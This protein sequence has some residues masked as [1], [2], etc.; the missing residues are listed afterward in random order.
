MRKTSIS[1]ICLAMALS[2][3]AQGPTPGGTINNKI[4]IAAPTAANLGTFG[5]VPVNLST[6]QLGLSVPIEPIV[7]HDITIPVKLDYSYQGFKPNEHPGWTGIGWSL[8]AGGVITRKKNGRV[9]EGAIPVEANVV[10][11]GVSHCPNPPGYLYTTHRQ[12]LYEK[13]PSVMDE[14]NYTTLL[15]SQRVLGAQGCGDFPYAYF[16]T[17][18]DE[19]YFNFNGFSGK[20]M[21][22]NSPWLGFVIST[23]SNDVFDI[24]YEM[25]T[26]LPI[27]SDIPVLLPYYISKF[28]VKT[29]DGYTY[30]FGGDYPNQKGLEIFYGMNYNANENH[31]PKWRGKDAYISSWYLTKIISPKGAVANFKYSES[32]FSAGLYPAFDLE[33]INHL[34][35]SNIRRTNYNWYSTPVNSNTYLDSITCGS[36]KVV[37]S[38]S[39]SSKKLPVSAAVLWQD[40]YQHEEVLVD[41]IKRFGITFN[42][43]MNNGIVAYETAYGYHNFFIRDANL[44]RSFDQKWQKL[45]GIDYYLDNNLRT[46]YRFD[47]WK[48]RQYNDDTTS[49]GTPG[50][51]ST[52]RLELKSIVKRGRTGDY[53]PHYSFSYEGQYPDTNVYKYI[54]YGTRQIDHWGFYNGNDWLFNTYPDTAVIVVDSALGANY[55]RSRA[56]VHSVLNRGGIQSITYPTG[57]RT[58][59]TYEPNTIRKYAHY[60]SVLNEIILVDLGKDSAV[61]GY[62]VRSIRSQDINVTTQPVSKDYFYTSTTNYIANRESSGVLNSGFPNYHR[63]D[64]NN[65]FSVGLIPSTMRG[66]Q[67][68]QTLSSNSSVPLFF[69]NSFLTYTDVVERLGNQSY[70]ASHFSNSD[71]SPEYRD[72][73]DIL[74]NSST[75]IYNG[76]KFHWYTS[77]E[78][79]RGKLLSESYYTRFD[80]IVKLVQYD[81]NNEPGRF[82]AKGVNYMKMDSKRLNAGTTG[83]YNL[84]TYLGTHPGYHGYLKSTLTTNYLSGSP[85]LI[86]TSYEYDENRNKTKETTYTNI[87]DGTEEITRY[88]NNT[89][90]A[91]ASNSS[92]SFIASVK[93]LQDKHLFKLPVETISN[94]IRNYN[95]L[96]VASSL[97]EYDTSTNQ[98]KS[99]SELETNAPIVNFAMASINGNIFSKHPDMHMDKTHIVGYN[100]PYAYPQTIINDRNTV[101]EIRSYNMDL[102][103]ATAVNASADDIYYNSFELN[104]REGWFVQIPS[105]F[106]TSDAVTGKTSVSLNGNIVRTRPN[107]LKIGKKYTLTYWAKGGTPILNITPDNGF[108][109]IDSLKGWQLY[110]ATFTAQHVW[111]EFTGTGL[112]DEVRVYPIGANMKSVTYDENFRILDMCNP[113]SHIVRY[114]YDEFDRLVLT[115]DGKG[116]IIQKT[117][118]GLQVTE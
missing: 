17:E 4:E 9:D 11:T 50:G 55:A 3:Q 80:T 46:S 106:T 91:P 96:T 42:N 108:Q 61:G 115:R 76:L 44:W 62:R 64:Y 29:H 57:G 77:K 60:D 95:P 28:T 63:K 24:T 49:I 32:G 101:S 7:F 5:T 51:S 14:T 111:V 41:Y 65:N 36:Q 99:H 37:F 6:G 16:D 43:W 72:K 40:R 97:F 19:F 117:E 10:D 13:S 38:R 75:Y 48:K 109:A 1:L 71:V 56:S 8:T 103:I 30:E 81:Y 110:K 79:E 112:L 113:A 116:N 45:T 86:S 18:P 114:E 78:F 2:G 70:I 84:R 53:R 69:E 105:L 39:G 83:T 68:Y 73:V 35:G 104:Q 102:Q 54:D 26:N 58:T 82:Y 66:G 47:Y 22:S 92:V 27:G 15:N 90:Y 85:V 23:S 74:P 118:Y 31:G 93:N 88:C 52:G 21:F 25:G 107:D 87:Q 34:A 98:L 33:H 59:F 67:V 94:K 100:Y 12:A 20:F 89:A